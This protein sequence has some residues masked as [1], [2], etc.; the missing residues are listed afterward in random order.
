MS[1]LSTLDG[2]DLAD[3]LELLEHLGIRLVGVLGAES[4]ENVAS[5]VPASHVREVART[6][7]EEGED[8]EEGEEKDELGGEREAVAQLLL[9][10]AQGIF[11]PI[12]AG[13]ADD[14]L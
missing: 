11:D 1:S 4:G 3:S 13:E 2:N 14:V 10:R 8:G 7:G 9:R 6:L 12:G 5:L